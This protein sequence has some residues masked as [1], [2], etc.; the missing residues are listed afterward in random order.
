[1]NW[2]EWTVDSSAFRTP[3]KFTTALR[4]LSMSRRQ[5]LT[6]WGLLNTED[7]WISL[8]QG[9]FL[10]FFAA[11]A[12]WDGDRGTLP[13]HGQWRWKREPRAP[14]RI[15]LLPWRFPEGDSSHASSDLCVSMEPWLE[16][17]VTQGKTF[18]LNPKFRTICIKFIRQSSGPG[19]QQQASTV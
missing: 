18:S 17:S 2:V 10:L 12:H 13:C 11:D 6:Q 9:D 8:K 19:T 7:C 5:K 4:F 3:G 1:M 15:S 14:G 16:A